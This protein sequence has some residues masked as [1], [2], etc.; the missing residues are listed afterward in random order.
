[1]PELQTRWDDQCIFC[2]IGQKKIPAKLTLE[3]DEVIVIDDLHPQAP[4]HKLIIPKCHIVNLNEIEMKQPQ[5]WGEF[6]YTVKKVAT[7]AGV[8][9]SGYRCV[10]NCG[11]NGG[12]T[13]SH[14]HLHLLADRHFN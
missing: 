13:V 10:I 4:V 6:L 3:T 12:Q 7:L 5:F 1:M 11:K 2:Q 14:L 9:E 8:L